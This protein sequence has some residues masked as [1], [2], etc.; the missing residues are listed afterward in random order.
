VNGRQVG[1]GYF[2][3]HGQ[4][5][6]AGR[7]H[8][9]DRDPSSTNRYDKIVIDDVYARQL[10][11]SGPQAAVGERIFEDD[12]DAWEI[13]GVVEGRPYD[14]Q[15]DAD[16]GAVY[17]LVTGNAGAYP[18]I[19]LS[20]NDVEGGLAAVKRVWAELA[21]SVA[22]DYKFEDQLFEQTF[23]TFERVGRL[24]LALSILAF[25]ISSIGLFGMA[26]HV[27]Q[28]RRH[29]IGVRKTLGSSAARVVGLLLADFSIPVIIANVLVW[30][31]AWLGAQIYLNPFVNRIDIGVLPFAIS[32]GITLVIAWAAV[33]AQTIRAATVQPAT[34]LRRA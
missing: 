13:I 2:D 23:S 11:F 33:S 5:T 10:G 15:S 4:K 1:F 29:E 7:V 17:R 18:L 8:S 24:F 22:L 14:I 32:L 3:I 34:V 31:V 6:L 25:L 21:P 30:P 12:G 27:T 28:K 9:S 16:G 19:R 20:A 26:V